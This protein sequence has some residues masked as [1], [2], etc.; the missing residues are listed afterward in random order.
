MSALKRVLLTSLG[1]VS[2]E[3]RCLG[4]FCVVEQLGGLPGVALRISASG[5][6]MNLNY[7][8]LTW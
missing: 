6:E 1:I 5:Y 7:S 3:L 2:S 8:T 4:R